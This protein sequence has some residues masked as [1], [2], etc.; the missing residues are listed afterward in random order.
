V[1]E[2]RGDEVAHA[3]IVVRHENSSGLDRSRR[4]RRV[5]DA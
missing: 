1:G 5:G 3:F 2:N 4:L